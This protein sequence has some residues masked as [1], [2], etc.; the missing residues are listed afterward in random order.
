MTGRRRLMTAGERG[1]LLR[2]YEEDR[3]G[4]KRYVFEHGKARERETW[5][6]TRAGKAEARA[7]VGE[8]GL[9]RA[10]HAEPDHAA[11]CE[12]VRGRT[13]GIDFQRATRYCR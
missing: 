1:N 6:H 9:R 2:L 3:A 13:N 12:S 4:V 7:G 8:V 5:P 10:A 11:R